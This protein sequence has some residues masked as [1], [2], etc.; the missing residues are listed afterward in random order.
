ME[1]KATTIP[2][3]ERMFT[4]SPMIFIPRKVKNMERGM[5]TPITIVALIS[6]RNKKITRIA[7]IIP[8]TPDCITVLREFVT[9][10]LS[11]AIIWNLRAPPVSFSHSS[12][13][14]L[15]WSVI[16]MALPSLRLYTSTTITSSPLLLII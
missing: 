12:R 14:S 4:V 5:D 16:F 11:S 6:F 3:M 9:V 10:V 8:M 15:I 7:I 2:E 13:T 1:P